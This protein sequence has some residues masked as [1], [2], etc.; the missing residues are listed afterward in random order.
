MRDF[1]WDETFDPPPKKS[2]LDEAEWN[3]DRR[4]RRT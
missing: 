3:Y 4:P 1:Y 2:L